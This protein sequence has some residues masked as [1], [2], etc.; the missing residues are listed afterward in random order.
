MGTQLAKSKR[1]KRRNIQRN[2]PTI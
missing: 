1:L 2:W